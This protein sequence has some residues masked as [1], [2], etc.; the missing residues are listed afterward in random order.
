MCHKIFK[1]FSI[2]NRYTKNT[3][4][5]RGSNKRRHDAYYNAL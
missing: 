2:N 4:E 1:Y 3:L 5:L